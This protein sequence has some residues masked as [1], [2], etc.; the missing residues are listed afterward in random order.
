LEKPSEG[1]CWLVGWLAGTSYTGRCVDRALAHDAAVDASSRSRLASRG[2]PRRPAPDPTGAAAAAAPAPPGLGTA[3]P[4][5]SGTGPPRPSAPC[6][7]AGDACGD[8]PFAALADL[9]GANMIQKSPSFACSRPPP[10]SDGRPSCGMSLKRGPQ[11]LLSF[12]DLH[13][14]PPARVSR[15]C[16]KKKP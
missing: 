11:L 6:P 13:E 7:S 8:G 9:L 16:T 2:A 12:C 15:A 4:I 5:I 1:C 14:P 10:G 3:R